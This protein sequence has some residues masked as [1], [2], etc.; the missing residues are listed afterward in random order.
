[1]LA[2]WDLL[3]G[4]VLGEKKKGFSEKSESLSICIADRLCSKYYLY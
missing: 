4:N 3:P 1:M 2:V